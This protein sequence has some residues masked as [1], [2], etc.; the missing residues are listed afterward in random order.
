M[1]ARGE[2]RARAGVNLDGASWTYELIDAEVRTPFLTHTPTGRT[3]CP[4]SWIA[5]SRTGRTG[6]RVRS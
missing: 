3:W 5:T 4:L 6:F 1:S 2:P